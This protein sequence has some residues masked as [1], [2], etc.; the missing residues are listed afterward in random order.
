METLNEDLTPNPLSMFMIQI[1]LSVASMERLSI[2]Q[3]MSSGYKNYRQN[4]GKVGKWG[5]QFQN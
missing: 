1:L 5:I 4:G 2:R 3:R